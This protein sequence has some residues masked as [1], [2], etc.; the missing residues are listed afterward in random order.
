M[1]QRSFH[2]PGDFLSAVRQGLA[3]SRSPAEAAI[4]LREAGYASGS[5]LYAA[6]ERGLAEQ[7]RGPVELLST[8][9]FWEALSAF[10]EE[11]G[12]GSLQYTRIHS[13]VAALDSPDWI[14]ADPNAGTSYPTCHLSVGILADL[15]GRLPGGQVAVLE[16]EC[17]SQGDPRCRFLFGAESTLNA[18]FQEIQAG[19]SYDVGIDRLG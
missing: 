8:S 2:L 17:R 7:N 18:V 5:A 15:L 16:A 13:G 12:W 4:V 9:D 6:F 10:F 1:N 3:A 19:E 14:E 11:S